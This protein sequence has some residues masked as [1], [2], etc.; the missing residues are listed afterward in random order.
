MDIDKLASL[1]KGTAL[2]VYLVAQ[3]GTFVHP[4][5]PVMFVTDGEQ[6]DLLSRLSDTLSIGEVRSFNQD[7]RFC[8]CVMAE[9]ASR[10][11]SP[12]VNDPGTAIDV[13]GRGV[14]VLSTFAQL[15][16]EKNA[17]QHP[18][19][20]IAPLAADALFDD[21]FSPIARDGAAMREVEIK[22]LK[23]LALLADGW[24][25]RYGETARQH[26]A[27]ALQY[28]E[29][30]GYVAADRR[31]ILNLHHSLFPRAGD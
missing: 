25:E 15:Q 7:P 24:P 28:I 11:L 10:A 8:L 2:H 23:A 20:H 26:A 21:F 13:I 22:V 17:V 12:A 29:R 27:E 9:I 4:T 5:R 19:I 6:R 3:P 18:N 14:R 16:P 1:L 30:A 31:R